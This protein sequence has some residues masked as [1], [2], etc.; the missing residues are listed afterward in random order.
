MS[1]IMLICLSMIM[2]VIYNNLPAQIDADTVEVDR[3]SP[4]AGMLMVRDS[5][6]G[7]PGPNEPVDFDFPPFI[8]MGFGP[9]G[10]FVSYY[11][12]DV[13]PK[14]PAPIYVLFRDGDSTPVAGQFNIIDVIPGDEGYNDFW[15]VQKVTVPADYEA[16]AATS[17]DDLQDE[18]YM[19]EPTELLVNCPVVPAGSVARKRLN[20]ESP[21]LTTGWYKDMLVFYFNFSEKALMPDESGM[22]PVSVIHVTFNINPD[23]PGGG[24]ASGFRMDSSLMRTHN[25]TSTLPQDND[26]SPLWQV[27]VYDN[28]DFDSVKDLTSA[29]NANTLVT[30]AADV[31]CPIVEIDFSTSVE[32]END[33]IPEKYILDQNFPNPFNPTTVI[34]FSIPEKQ[35]VSLKVYN[36]IGE[37]VAE[38]INNSLDAGSY[39]F[40]WNA[41]NVASGIYFYRIITSSFT[42]TRKMVLLK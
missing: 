34:K 39:S 9:Q 24:P 22:V 19:I 5:V 30:G 12:F 15:H 17:L 29:L 36:S 41:E 4:E 37:E 28:A 42:Q 20:N 27:N 7:L 40:E 26:Y 32:R 25:V 21:E 8:T 33:I 2:I 6:N 1:K 13:Q 14:T 10:Q 16:N 18:E 31:N 11:N 23:Q 35:N 38:L 3:F